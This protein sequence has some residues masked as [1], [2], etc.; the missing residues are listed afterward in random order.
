MEL[1]CIAASS[2]DTSSSPS[3]LDVTVEKS[4]TKLSSFEIISTIICV[5]EVIYEI[6]I[7]QTPD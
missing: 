2:P 3:P 4:N 6:I 7:R 5:E 1:T